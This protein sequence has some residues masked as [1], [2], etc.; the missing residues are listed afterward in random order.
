MAKQE[1]VAAIDVG[2]NGI[3]LEISRL[4]GSS[5]ICRVESQREAIRLGHDVF[6]S[7]A[8]EDRTMARTVRTFARFKGLLEQH[9]VRRYRAVATSATREAS[10]GRELVQAIHAA[11]GLDLEIIDPIEEAKLM[12]LA[13]G[14]V[15]DFDQMTALLIDMGGGSVEITIVRDG[16]TLGCE[17]LRAGPV[18][19]LERLRAQG[20]P[21]TRAEQLI[22]RFAHTARGL[23]EAELEDD[24]LDKCIGIGGNMERL[25]KLRLKLLAKR[26]EGKV[27]L[28]DLDAIIGQLSTMTPEQRVRDLD[29][30]PD[31][32]DVIVIAAIVL[33]MIVR[34]AGVSKVCVPGVGLKDGLVMQLAATRDA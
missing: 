7:K 1:H 21:E 12:Q 33:R 10:N 4:N 28:T 25:A 26:K 19:L 13:V 11:T 30:R 18:R 31:R 6:T 14:T 29:M 23:I 5:S 16:Q 34:D 17:S 9:G 32:A 24:T 2:S 27:K 8:F 20:L 22:K 15:I 3:R